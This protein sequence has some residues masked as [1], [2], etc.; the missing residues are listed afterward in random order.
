MQ[1]QR[2]F[3]AISRIKDCGVPPLLKG[4]TMI[5]DTSAKA[6]LLDDYFSS[7][8][9]N[10]DL[11]SVPCIESL[12][13]PVMEPISINSEGVKNLLDNLEGKKASGPVHPDS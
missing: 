8:F 2:N 7:V 6:K 11:S 10:E 5:S 3:G 1:Q 4:D 13:I 9:V 12:S